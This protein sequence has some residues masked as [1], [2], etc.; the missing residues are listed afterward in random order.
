MPLT[1]MW[2]GCNPRA[3]LDYARPPRRSH[4]YVKQLYKHYL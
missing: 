1:G 3:L 4:L 2:K